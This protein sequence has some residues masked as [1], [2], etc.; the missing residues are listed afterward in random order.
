[1]GLGG[2]SIAYCQ[3]FI[4]NM[5]YTKDK[6]RVYFIVL[7]AIFSLTYSQNLQDMRRLKA[8]Y[9]QERLSQQNKDTPNI[10]IQNNFPL[11]GQSAN[12]EI[13]PYQLSNDAL[14]SLKSLKSFFG[15]NFFTKRSEVNFW[16]NLPITK[17]YLLGSGDELIVSL[18]GETQLRQT[19]TIS[20]DG[21]IF[22]D[23]VGLLN[24]SGKSLNESHQFLK[25]QFGRVYATLISSKPTS[26]IDVSLGE[27]RSINVNFVG[28]VLYPGVYPIHPSS[29]LILG[30]IQ[31]GGV[32]TT[33]SL[34][35]IEII[36]GATTIS[37]VDLYEYFLKGDMPD[38][39][40]LRD[41]DIVFVPVRFSSIK[42]DSAVFRPG[43]YESKPNES[44][45]QMLDYAGGLKANASSS[46]ELKRILPV[47]KRIGLG[48]VSENYYLNILDTD[49]IIVQNGDIITVRKIF[50][51]VNQVEIIGQVKSPGI[52]S[53]YSGMTLSEL[54]QLSSGFEDTTF[55]KS[56]YHGRAEIVR[57]D[58]M[59]R[60]ER[61]IEVPLG[62]MVINGVKGIDIKLENLDKI[63]IHANLNFFEKKTVQ[64]LG[65][66]SIPGNYPVLN[67]RE[68]LSSF[69]DR[70]GGFSSN[71]YVDGIEIFRDSLRVAWENM[72]I[73]LVSGDS[74]VIKEKPGVIH[75]KGEVYN[76]G[77]IEFQEGKPLNYY[78]NSAG[79][80]TL[81]GEKSDIIVIYPNGV[82]YPKKLFNSPKIRDGSTIVVNSKEQTEPLKPTEL[83]S[84][85]ASLLSSLVTIILLV[86]QLSASP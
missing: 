74:V 67:N 85:L 56:V 37:K 31:A 16:E 80:V 28:S 13:I 9:E 11:D 41:N 52:Y 51:N 68:T 61:V 17:D 66:V 43:I 48:I 33:G 12:V 65:E 77:F 18:W 21:T 25:K 23:K 46:I 86:N 75:V 8:Q 84:S 45:K 2:R 36:R 83:A 4:I 27:L 30:L 62:D 44:L 22:D 82:V 42:I 38:D 64:I 26:Y 70:A 60:Y 32:D 76:E 72:N 49:T 20:R 40:Q 29:N 10:D 15:Y 81:Y 73:G 24:L 50:D 69:I 71:A 59:S 47:E 55:W 14:D 3:H 63:V 54:L 57:R 78:I 34:R 7:F 5:I 19:Y 39:I 53:Y 58:P 35:N 79:G 6:Q 1:M